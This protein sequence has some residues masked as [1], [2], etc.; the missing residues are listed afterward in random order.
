MTPRLASR[1]WFLANATKPIHLE[2]LGLHV[3]RW[4]FHFAHNH[5]DVTF[6]MGVAYSGDIPHESVADAQA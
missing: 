4:E 6:I 1:K 3:G 5:T 2:A